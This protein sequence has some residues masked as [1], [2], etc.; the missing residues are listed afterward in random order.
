MTISLEDIETLLLLYKYKSVEQVSKEMNISDGTVKYR[1]K[2]IESFLNRKIVKSLGT[3]KVEF[4]DYGEIAIEEFRKIKN[5]IEKLKIY[6]EQTTYEIK[7]AS[8]EVAGI[9][10]LP[11]IAKAFKD[12][13]AEYKI[14]IEVLSTLDVFKS[15][16][17][18]SADIGFVASINFDEVK[19]T[20]SN[21]RV[22]RLVKNKL[23]VIGKKGSLRKN[24]ISVKEILNFPYIGRKYNSGIQAE[25]RKILESEGFSENDLNIVYKLDNSSSVINAVIEGIGIS[26]VSFIQAKRYIEAG[27]LD[28]AELDTKVESYL[29]AIDPWRGKNEI[30][31]KFINFTVNFITENLNI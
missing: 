5:I 14:N 9:Y 31:N 21:Y 11:Q 25:V 26:I 7:I 8:G 20:L 13:Y 28:Y 27:L 24:K 6:G 16:E 22:I 10:F 3:R 23:V 4:T 29:Y 12:K 15:L 30:I 1:V 18:G 19:S 2:N 17:D